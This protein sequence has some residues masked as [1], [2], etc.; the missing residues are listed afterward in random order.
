MVP[1]SVPDSSQRAGVPWELLPNV[2]RTFALTIPVLEAPVRD[3][4]AV[5]YLLCRIADTIEDAEGTPDRVRIQLFGLFLD[6]IRRPGNAESRAVFQQH[7]CGEV[8]RHHR[9]LIARCSDVLDAHAGLSPWARQSIEACLEEMVSGMIHF[10][11]AG[12]GASEPK[13]PCGSVEDLEQYCHV[14]A[15]TVGILLTRL[16]SPELPES[17]ATPLRYEQGRRFGLGLQITNVLKDAEKDR[18]RGISY[19]PL[20]SE[21]TAAPLV[22]LALNHLDRAQEYI[23]SIPS[24]RGDLRLFC[25]WACHLALATLALIA[26]HPARAVKVSREDLSHLLERSRASVLN[27][28]QLAEQ[29][30]DLRRHV[31]RALPVS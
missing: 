8:D 16:F 24:A 30:S 19:V 9:E 20:Q 22:H 12:E 6:M 29:Y 13:R 11:D 25:V 3:Q 31:T 21:G 7:W 28:A 4:V 18:R 1:R 23:V 26:Q 5:A 14:V 15:G 10:L 17:W 27:D 2:S